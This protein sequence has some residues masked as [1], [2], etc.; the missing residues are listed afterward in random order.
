[1]RAYGSFGQPNPF[2]GYLGYLAPVAASL[3][4]WS[5]AQRWRERT[6][7]RLMATLALIAVTIVLTAGILMSWSRGGWL[8]LA[9][10]FA[11]VAGLRNRR[12]VLITAAL[13]VLLLVGAGQFGTGWLPPAIAGRMQDLGSYV[14]GP[15]PGRTEITDENFSVLERLAH[16]QAGL[17]MLEDKPWLGVGIGNYA[18]SYASYPQPHWYEALGHAHNVFVN[19]AAETGVLGLAAFLAFWIGAAIF[20]ARLSWAR[21]GWISAM[22]LGVLGTWAYLSVHSLFDNLFVRHVQLQLALLL[23]ALATLTYTARQSSGEAPVLSLS[24]LD[25]GSRGTR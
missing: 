20:A 21:A 9:A 16:W 11:V 4:L 14:A 10:A 19:F 6:L 2:A 5:A 1:M 7:G 23:A 22:A 24:G 8:A 25:N 18:A 3:A 12:T 17:H 13:I 15:D